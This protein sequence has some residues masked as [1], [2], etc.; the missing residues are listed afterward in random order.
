[1]AGR[2]TA[3]KSG[4]RLIRA[5]TGQRE[6]L[7]KNLVVEPGDE[8]WIPEKEYRDWWAFTQSTVR[9]LAE[10]LTLIVIVRSI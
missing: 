4:A 10:T 7:N 8:I 1:M 3:E 2:W 5:R 9:T 6:K